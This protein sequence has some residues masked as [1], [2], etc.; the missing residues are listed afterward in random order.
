MEDLAM[1]LPRRQQ[2]DFDGIPPLENGDRL[3]RAEFER[4]YE[5]MPNLKK[6]ELIEGVVHVPSPARYRCHSRPQSHLM[7]W[8]IAYEAA[9]PGVEAAD[10][11]TVRLDLDNETQPDGLLLIDPERGGQARISADDYVELAPELVAEIAA[12]SVSYD[13]GTKLNAYRRNGVREYVVWRVLNRAIDWFALRES[14]FVPL[15]PDERGILK[16]EIFPGLWLNAAAMIAGD[17]R[18]VLEVLHEGLA[19]AEHAAFLARLQA[20]GPAS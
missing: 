3:T 7:G 19:S 4:R 12:S 13:L 18:R 8:L 11:S 5:A 17:L 1:S 2:S 16:S 15:D 20:A 6:A 14:D 10:N 9:T